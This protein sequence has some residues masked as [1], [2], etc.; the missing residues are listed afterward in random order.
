M[1]NVL[2]GVMVIVGMLVIGFMTILE[3]KE[4]KKE[5]QKQ[6]IKNN[7]N[8]FN[9]LKDEIKVIG[10]TLINRYFENGDG[11]SAYD[12]I[13]LKDLWNNIDIELN[14]IT[15]D[16]FDM[17]SKNVKNEIQKVLESTLLNELVN[18]EDIINLRKEE[19]NE[20]KETIK[21]ELAMHKGALLYTFETKEWMSYGVKY[22]Y[23]TQEYSYN[24]RYNWLVSPVNKNM[25]TIIEKAIDNSDFYKE[26]G[27]VDGK[28]VDLKESLLYNVFILM[29]T[30]INM[31]LVQEFHCA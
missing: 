29:D 16:I 3:V 22:I 1:L 12:R 5:Q 15:E 11:S 13:L 25:G 7:I 30:Y 14:E 17:S 31:E 20:R 23:M 19:L 28:I 21:S 26:S 18:I 9:E 6:L 24:R 8:F 4:T 2:G 10:Y 27:V